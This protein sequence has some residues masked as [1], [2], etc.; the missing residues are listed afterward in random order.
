MTRAEEES[1]AAAAAAAE[2][3]ENYVVLVARGVV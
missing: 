1:I 3:A 2:I